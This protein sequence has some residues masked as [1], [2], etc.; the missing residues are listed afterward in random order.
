MGTYFGWMSVKRKKNAALSLF[1]KIS[2]KS[3][4]HKHDNL[5]EA[6]LLEFKQRSLFW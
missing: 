1:S 2:R 4:Q 5:K 3:M 6:T